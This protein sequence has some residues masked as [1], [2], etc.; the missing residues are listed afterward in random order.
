MHAPLVPKAKVKL[1]K[2][3]LKSANR[4]SGYT[5]SPRQNLTTLEVPSFEQELIR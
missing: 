2:S 5:V 1:T 4:T 3:I